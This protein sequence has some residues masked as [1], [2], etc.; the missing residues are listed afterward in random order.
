MLS[1]PPVFYMFSLPL[2]AFCTSF[3]VI[4]LCFSLS[5]S[6]CNLYLYSARRSCLCLFRRLLLFLCIFCLCGHNRN[7]PSSTAAVSDQERTNRSR[8]FSFT[9]LRTKK[10]GMGVLLHTLFYWRSFFSF[11]LYS[12]TFRGTF[13]VSESFFFPLMFWKPL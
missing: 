1:L 5:H 9:S 13:S 12:L 3:E 11:T 2:W 4:P 6:I 8:D 10:M 7:R